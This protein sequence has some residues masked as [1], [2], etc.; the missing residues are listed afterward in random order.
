M[1]LVINPEL[2]TV[3]VLY[4][5]Q[6]PQ[7]PVTDIVVHSATNRVWVASRGAGLGT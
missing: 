1:G 6:I 2:L 3:N 5:Q 7:A 4:Q